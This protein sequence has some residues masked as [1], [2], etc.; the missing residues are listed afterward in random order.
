MY[1][2]GRFLLFFFLL[3]TP[4]FALSQ[5]AMTKACDARMAQLVV[6]SQKDPRFEGIKYSNVTLHMAGCAPVSLCN[7]VSAVLGV[8]DEDTAAAMMKEMLPLLT[9]LGKYEKNAI[10]VSKLAQVLDRAS[11]SEEK[12]PA[13]SRV[14][15][16]YEGHIYASSDRLSADLLAEKLEQQDG[17]LL[18]GRLSVEK[19]WEEAMDILS[20]LHRQR[21]DDAVLSI[22]AVG[23]G[24]ESTGMP[25]R[26]GK[27][28]HYVSVFLHTGTFFE[29]GTFYLLDSMPRALEGE[30]SGYEMLYTSEYAFPKDG[31]N[32]AFNR[33]FS[34][35]RLS[36]TVL[37]IQMNMDAFS[38]AMQLYN[39]EESCGQLA[40]M[41]SPVRFYGSGMAIVRTDAP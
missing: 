33:R 5:E 16:G 9:H 24:T 11:L 22:G 14:V 37:K 18:C 30:P 35:C 39:Q 1:I 6:L 15:G 3:L 25:F 23:A 32:A 19:G 31:E 7:M 28:G 2:L 41:L 12:R 34:V 10:S 4:A 20:V 26:S 40:D 27:S 21:L 8:T 17:M 29:S 38:A 36:P 13:L